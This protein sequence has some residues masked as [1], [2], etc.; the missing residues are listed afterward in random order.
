MV[1]YGVASA[2]D[3][4]GIECGGVSTGCES[5]GASFGFESGGAS[6]GSEFGG[7]SAGTATVGTLAVGDVAVPASTCWSD[8]S[9]PQLGLVDTERVLHGGA[10]HVPVY[11][12]GS[13]SSVM[14]VHQTVLRGGFLKKPHI[15]T[16]LIVKD[17]LQFI[18]LDK[19][20]DGLCLYLTG[21]KAKAYPLKHVLF[22]DDM[23]KTM[24][25]HCNAIL[26][27]TKAKI[28][29]AH[30]KAKSASATMQSMNTLVKK[31]VLSGLGRAH[32]KR[33][34]LAALP[35]VGVVNMSRGG[36]DWHPMCLIH[37]GTKNVSMQVSVDNFTKL[38]EIV[39]QCLDEEAA[40]NRAGK[41]TPPRAL[42]RRK[43]NPHHPKGPAHERQYY[44][45]SKGIWI[46]RTIKKETTP[47]SGS[48][49][50]YV[51][52]R[53]RRFLKSQTANPT[54]RSS[55]PRPGGKYRCPP[56]ANKSKQRVLSGDADPE[57]GDD[58]DCASSSHDLFSE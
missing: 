23:Q 46:T 26:A 48:G 57:P 27:D 16:D 53:N 39:R 8:T 10:L 32:K 47:P 56:G 3:P 24:I 55:G 45:K 9:R 6:A 18:T 5:G 4:N 58:D 31:T 54:S 30:D 20:S 13:E 11:L 43:S 28:A 25:K 19:T 17:G 42:R 14:T 12:N 40:L 52:G 38:F 7:A 35:S 41:Q 1:S 29:E 50:R 2:T 22:F 36:T 44:S 15:F 21:V 37:T 33:T 34:C 49:N 51:A